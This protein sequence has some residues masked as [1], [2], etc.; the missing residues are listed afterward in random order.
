MRLDTLGTLVSILEAAEFI[1]EDTDRATFEQFVRDR[2]MRQLTERNPAN[3]GEA[4]TRLRRKEPLLASRI[5]DVHRIIGMRNA[6]IH[7]YDTIDNEQVWFAVQ[8]T[9]P[10][11][12]QEVEGLLDDGQ[13]EQ[14]VSPDG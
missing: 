5:T 4:L 9:L 12:C 10:L 2:R 11:L 7:G 14:Q 8:V 6:L 13:R 3:I 1:A